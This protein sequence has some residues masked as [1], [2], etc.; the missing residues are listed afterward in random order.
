MK[1]SWGKVREKA[2]RRLRDMKALR[3][4]CRELI[5]ESTKEDAL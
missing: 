5:H 2:R 4:M 3:K 1:T